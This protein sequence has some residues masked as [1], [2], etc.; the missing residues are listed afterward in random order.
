MAV[1]LE[2]GVL[3]YSCKSRFWITHAIYVVEVIVDI[4]LPRQ[5]EI[6]KDINLQISN[7]SKTVRRV[8]SRG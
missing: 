8:F 1:L 4:H 3:E 5:K 2:V 6:G 7:A